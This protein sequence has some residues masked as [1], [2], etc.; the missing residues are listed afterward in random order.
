MTH[1]RRRVSF[2]HRNTLRSPDRRDPHGTC[3][4]PSEEHGAHATGLMVRYSE[5]MIRTAT[6]VYTGQAQGRID[7][8]GTWS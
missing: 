6:Y 2:M 5:E 8:D 4:Q 3:G 7:V 1:Q